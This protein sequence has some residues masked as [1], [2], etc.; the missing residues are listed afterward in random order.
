MTVNMTDLF[1]LLIP[2]ASNFKLFAFSC[3]IFVFILL[4]SLF[5]LKKIPDGSNRD[6][7]HKTYERVIY[8]DG[9]LL[10]LLLISSLP[11]GYFI[12]REETKPRFDTFTGTIRPL[13]YGIE[14]K[15]S[16]LYT[17]ERSVS[18]FGETTDK[19]ILYLALID[20]VQKEDKDDKFPVKIIKLRAGLDRQDC[21]LDGHQEEGRDL[22]TNVDEAIRFNT[23]NDDI[24]YDGRKKRDFF[25]TE[26]GD[27]GYHLVPSE[28]S[29]SNNSRPDSRIQQASYG[30]V[31][32]VPLLSIEA[33]AQE[34][35]T[36]ETDRYLVEGEVIGFFEG[37]EEKLARVL[38]DERAGVE[39]KIQALE[40]L[41]M[42]DDEALGRFMRLNM[43][44]TPFA[45]TM[46]D[47]S[48]HTN[49]EVSSTASNILNRV[50]L[51]QFIFVGVGSGEEKREMN[52]SI[53]FS[54]LGENERARVIGE[55]E[56]EGN[57]LKAI[58]EAIPMQA[59]IPTESKQGD[60]YYVKA[61]W[62]NG[63]IV[64]GTEIV[65]FDCLTRLFNRELI[66]SR[67]LQQEKELMRKRKGTRYVYWY[68]D[69]W[70]RY[71]AAKIEKCGAKATFVDGREI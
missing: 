69:G 49:V 55:I 9:I 17:L 14:V 52:A 18:V 23:W 42:K 53:I 64:S 57:G 8:G 43:D 48:R 56:G 70:A 29:E 66:T 36:P 38:H 37:Q 46:L 47:L 22:C 40:R 31:F 58:L 24:V 62:N 27:G 67:T 51:S 68:S 10:G 33:Y 60:R 20:K 12:W 19:I 13:D 34:L 11:V 21:G 50:D 35:V 44:N 32:K 45:A 65:V 63:N 1:E 7:I 71:I 2:L 6:K 3:F 26:N 16:K 5:G 59:L 61:D 25:I 28:D 30:I 54:R 4:Y 39:T 41:K 15:S